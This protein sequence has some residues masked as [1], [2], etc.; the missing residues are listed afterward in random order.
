MQATRGHLH[1]IIG[2]LESSNAELQSLNEELQ[3][4]S[5]ELQA[6][7]EELSTLNDELQSKSGELATVNDIL[8]GIQD[9]IQLGLMVVDRQYRVRRFNPL[10]GR[11]FGLMPEDLGQS[12]AGVPRTLPLPDLRPKVEAVIAGGPPLVERVG[13]QDR[14]YLM[15]V[16]PHM[17]PTGNRIG[18]L[19]TFADIS[20]LAR[21]EAQQREAEQR[22]RLFMDHSPAVSWIKD[23]EGRMVW[24]SGTFETAFG[25]RLADCEGK[26]RR[27]ALVSGA[28][29]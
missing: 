26:T 24:V 5:E 17:D 29:G 15:Q 20:E 27:R 6:S 12:L 9:S 28:R 10:A 19:V 2:E 23:A 4:A 8:S 14:Q 18:A 1:A 13:D 22:F 25:V 21:A 16:V 11:I 7:N 3:V